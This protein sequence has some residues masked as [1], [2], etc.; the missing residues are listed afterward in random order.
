M[1]DKLK[2]IPNLGFFRN[3]Y[4]ILSSKF[5][6][7][8]KMTAPL[9]SVRIVLIPNCWNRFNTVGAGKLNLLNF[10]IEIIANSG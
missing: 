2:K 5:P 8:L 10:P 7:V 1:A 6:S 3:I 4:L 9:S